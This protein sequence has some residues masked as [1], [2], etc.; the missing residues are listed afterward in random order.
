ML[1]SCGRASRSDRAACVKFLTL[2]VNLICLR[3]KVVQSQTMNP[4]SY[5]H[6]SSGW[7][8]AYDTYQ[9][10]LTAF[11]HYQQQV[12]FIFNSAFLYIRTVLNTL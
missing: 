3:Q 11:S 5:L 9:T 4:T 8:D 2:E 7:Y 1:I 10:S 12:T 6:Q